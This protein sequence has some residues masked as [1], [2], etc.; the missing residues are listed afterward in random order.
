MRVHLSR[1]AAASL[2]MTAGLGLLTVPAGANGPTGTCLQITGGSPTYTAPVASTTTTTGHGANAVTTTTRTVTGPGSFQTDVTLGAPSCPG[3]QY[4]FYISSPDGSNLHWTSAAVS[5]SVGS[6]TA[7][8]SGGGVV[9]VTVIGD[10][11]T[12]TTT[13]PITVKGSLG[14]SCAGCFYTGL[15]INS[16][17]QVST[18]GQSQVTSNVL[19]APVNGGGGTNYNA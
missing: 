15:A 3:V 19:Q 6:S 17:V 9:Q 8:A 2:V 5:P 13:D 1:L 14:Q 12:G 7:I 10:G 11:Q 16:Y 4:T 18:A